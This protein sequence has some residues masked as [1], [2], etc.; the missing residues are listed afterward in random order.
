MHADSFD[1]LDDAVLKECTWN[2]DE[3]RLNGDIV[4]LTDFRVSGGNEA[5]PLVEILENDVIVQLEGVLQS[6]TLER[7]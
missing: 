5:R 6:S 3:A 7:E 1:V 4:H 2:G